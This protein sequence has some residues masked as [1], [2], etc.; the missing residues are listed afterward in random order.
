MINERRS[1][2]LQ[3]TALIHEAFIRLV[4]VR[5]MQFQDRAHFMA[6]CA[7]IMRRILIDWARDYTSKKRGGGQIH[8]SLESPPEFAAGFGPDLL[9]LDDALNRLALLDD[10][11]AKVELRIYGWLIDDEIATGPMISVETVGRDCKFSRAWLRKNLA[12]GDH[13]GS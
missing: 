8:L 9:A 5:R 7:R 2:T 10:R 3:T 13:H 6:L 12:R 11:K 4:D 1:H